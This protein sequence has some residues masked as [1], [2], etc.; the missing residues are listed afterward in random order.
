MLFG[1]SHFFKLFNLHEN[2][3]KTD[4]QVLHIA[5]YYLF[6]W[7]PQD[8]YLALCPVHALKLLQMLRSFVQIRAA[9]GMRKQTKTKEKL[10][11]ENEKILRWENKVI[12]F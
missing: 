6:Q 2:Y 5:P 7:Y 11:R 3:A 4:R 8:L 10:D 12:Q 1:F 9:K